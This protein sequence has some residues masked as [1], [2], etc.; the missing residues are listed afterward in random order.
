MTAPLERKRGFTLIEIAIVLVVIGLLLSGGLLAVAPVLQSSRVTETNSKL[1]L[2]EDALLLYAL[3]NSCLPC[4]ATGNL[5][6]TNAN[7]G[8]AVDDTQGAYQVACAT[9]ACTNLA[10]GVVPWRNLGLSE[11]DATD[12][13]GYRISYAVT[14]NLAQAPNMERVGTVYPQGTLVVNNRQAVDLTAV[15]QAAYVLLSHG[16][17]GSLGFATTSGVQKI[18]PNGS[19]NQLDNSNGTPFVQD[20]LFGITGANY[21]D[22]IVRWRTGPI[23]VQLCGVGRCGNPS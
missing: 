19:A 7:A 12:G 9:D 10:Q 16:P 4:P 18:D 6:S 11:A 5:A 1:D 21:F 13:F 3:R 15:E 14:S 20:E 23:I 17:D 22:D 2:I 8:L